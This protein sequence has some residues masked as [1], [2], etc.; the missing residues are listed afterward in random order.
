M[1][2]VVYSC[3]HCPFQV[4]ISR[5]WVRWRLCPD[6]LRN[7]VRVP[8][9]GKG[10][11]LSQ[12]TRQCLLSYVLMW[13]HLLQGT[14]RSG[15][16]H[17]RPPNSRN[18]QTQERMCPKARA[19]GDTLQRLQYRRTFT[20]YRKHPMGHHPDHSNRRQ[21]EWLIKCLSNSSHQHGEGRCSVTVPAPRAALS[22]L[23][24]L[25]G[26]EE[27]CYP[28][29]KQTDCS[30]HHHPQGSRGPNEP[31]SAHQQGRHHQP[32][33]LTVPWDLCNR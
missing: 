27:V 5:S 19:H 17:E 2:R 12:K 24:D 33:T 28:H 15:A 3:R 23:R 30:T 25:T 26:E 20:S 18:R 21:S 8:R 31:W 16:G 13:A 32:D 6:V 4:S 14:V 22:L 7:I 9:T 11:S 1:A 10:A 29:K